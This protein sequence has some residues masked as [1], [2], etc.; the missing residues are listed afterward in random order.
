[1]YLIKLVEML[2]HIIGIFLCYSPIALAEKN[3]FGRDVCSSDSDCSILK[4]C[5]SSFGCQM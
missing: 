2:L 3:S 1:M 5:D 4:E